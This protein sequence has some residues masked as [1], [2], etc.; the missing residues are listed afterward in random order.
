MATNKKNFVYKISNSIFKIMQGEL[1]AK[2]SLLYSDV[3][4]T[5]PNSLAYD[6]GNQTL[7]FIKSSDLKLYYI[8]S[9]DTVASVVANFSPPLYQPANAAY[10]NNSIWYFEFNSNILV[11]VDL[12]YTSG[13]PSVS[14]KTTYTI[15]G[16]N[17]PA[18]GTV[19]VNTNTF[20]D[21]TI[22]A[23][24]GIL[25]GSTSRGRFY[26]ITL[27][28]P[29]ST[30]TE[31]VSSPGN[32]RSVGLQLVYNNSTNV[33]YGHNHKTG[34]WYTINTSTGA[35][36]ELNVSSSLFRDLGGTT[37]SAMYGAD[38]DGNIYLVDITTSSPQTLNQFFLPSGT[39]SVGNNDFDVNIQTNIPD[40][41]FRI[42]IFET[43]SDPNVKV[44]WGDGT[45]ST[46]IAEGYQ[47][48]FYEDVI[49]EPVKIQ[50]DF[51]GGE[52]RIGGRVN[53][54]FAGGQWTN[55]YSSLN[56]IKSVNPISGITNLSSIEFTNNQNLSGVPENLFDTVSG[57][58]TNLNN[59]FENSSIT[60]VPSGLL[61]NLT[62]VTGYIATFKNCSNLNGVDLPI[63]TFA[64]TNSIASMAEFLDNTTISNYDE[65][66]DWLY[67]QANSVSLSNI[68]L[69]AC[70]N[71]TSNSTGSTARSNL[72][73][74]LGW[75]INDGSCAGDPPLPSTPPSTSAPPVTTPPPSTPPV[76]SSTTSS[77]P[78]IT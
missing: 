22:D 68:I 62:S 64:V 42:G 20:G 18:E 36:T 75:T 7:F 73:N 8:Q 33:L 41:G 27:S 69:G 5:N 40:Q 32:D 70:Q 76:T 21:I 65:F 26:K 23:N 55:D 61:T 47:E 48:H 11:K 15:S 44:N 63:P 10:Y 67:T 2:Q 17:L 43:T 51:A 35:K 57:S 77:S 4:G 72:I 39:L 78:G 25:Y 37:S 19:G 14:N 28:N 45:T 49:A 50:G 71:S 3:A 60:G 46:Y 1:E 30:F 66:L 34:I 38:S 24:N 9:G 53:T 16:M 12:T 13:V 6:N 58:I 74:N 54:I 29:T 59:T 52:L 56:I 31:I